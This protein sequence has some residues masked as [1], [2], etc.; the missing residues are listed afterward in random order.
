MYVL[1]LFTILE[2]SMTN[3]LLKKIKIKKKLNSMDGNNSNYFPSYNGKLVKLPINVDWKYL[4]T[5]FQVLLT[6]V[7]DS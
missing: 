7:E 3:V 1:H 5:L 2:T 6:T 4:L